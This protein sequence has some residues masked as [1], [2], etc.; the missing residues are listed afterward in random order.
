MHRA[1]NECKE[2]IRNT[3]ETKRKQATARLLSKN[4]ENTKLRGLPSPLLA[5]PPQR[6]PMT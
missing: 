2:N 6:T 3:N 1:S 5:L 4:C